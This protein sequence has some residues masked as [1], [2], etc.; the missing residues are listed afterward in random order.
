MKIM[1]HLFVPALLAGWAMLAASTRAA[2]FHVASAQDLQNAL[3]AAAGNGADNIVWLTNGY[4]TGT[5]SYNSSAT[6]SL[7]VWPAERFVNAWFR[8]VQDAAVEMLESEITLSI[9]VPLVVRSSTVALS[10]AVV[11]VSDVRTMYEPV[12]TSEVVEAGTVKSWYIESV[13]PAWAMPPIQAAFGVVST[14]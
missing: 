3:T 7:T 6:Y 9:F 4:Y 12:S 1:R 14:E 13:A 10:F 8:G 5:F 11:P 2:D